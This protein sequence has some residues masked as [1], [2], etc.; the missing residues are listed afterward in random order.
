MVKKLIGKSYL[1]LILLL[2]YAPILLL[3]AFS[4]T[5]STHIGTWNGF[6]LD[7]YKQMFQNE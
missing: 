6:S 4:F 7:L 1:I 5:D 2:M 3:I